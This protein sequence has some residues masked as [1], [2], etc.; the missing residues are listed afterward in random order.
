[1]VKSYRVKLVSDEYT[2]IFLEK[3]IKIIV[4]STN[5]PQPTQK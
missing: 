4:S 1:M 5:G 3:G 2:V